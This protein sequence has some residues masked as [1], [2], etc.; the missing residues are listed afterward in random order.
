MGQALADLGYDEPVLLS[1]AL[2]L[3]F[4]HGGMTISALRTEARKG[5][6]DVMRIAGKDWT[7]AR[8]IKEMMDR[9]RVE[10]SPRALNSAPNQTAE[11]SGSSETAN[12]IDEQD[13]LR[14]RLQTPNSRF[15]NT[16][17]T[18]RARPTH[19]NVVRLPSSSPP[20]SEST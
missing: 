16:S 2:G 7:T 9:C 5:R 6:L 4:P 19:Q 14:I 17:P 3:F 8:A 12:C 20:S 15:A 11:G 10:R 18:K 13:A 1:R